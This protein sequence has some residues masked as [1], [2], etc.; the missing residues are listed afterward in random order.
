MTLGFSD[1]DFNVSTGIEGGGNIENFIP[2]GTVINVKL[3]GSGDYAS[4]VDAVDYLE[5]K[6]SNG[7]V[8]IKL[9]EGTFDISNNSLSVGNI[10]KLQIEG[11]SQQ[12]T[13]VSCSGTG[14]A[15]NSENAVISHLIFKN[16]SIQNTN[17]KSGTG[18]RAALQTCLTVDNVTLESF[19]TA[20]NV[21]MGVYCHI[22]SSITVKNCAVGLI[23]R[24]TGRISSNGGSV[25]TFN[26]LTTAWK[27]ETGGIIAPATSVANITYTSVT[28]K[29]SQTVGQ[30]N[31][32]GAIGGTLQ[33]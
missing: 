4:L 21:D 30:F 3:D 20:I 11:I 7:Q 22:A 2:D 10:E 23:C 18:I 14:I 26:N 33:N 29:C 31:A 5:D 25:I 28:N 13:I 32:N 6:W 12:N 8:T 9:G 27:V 1:V 16:L 17:N 19:E 24:R 15:F